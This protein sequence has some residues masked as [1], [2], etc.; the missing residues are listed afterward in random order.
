LAA[1]GSRFFLAVLQSL[2]DKISPVLTAD[3]T[4]GEPVPFHHYNNDLIFQV[5]VMTRAVTHSRA[6]TNNFRKKQASPTTKDRDG[7]LQAGYV[8]TD[9][10]VALRKKVV[11]GG[12]RAI[13]QFG[14]AKIGK[15]DAVG[16]AFIGAPR[17][18]TQGD[19]ARYH[20]MP[21]DGVVEQSFNRAALS[22][23]AGTNRPPRR[24]TM[25]RLTYR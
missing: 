2:P 19:L 14:D 1:L 24:L 11:V 10:E 13:M 9:S 20:W 3:S 25:S 12:V 16:S 8:G 7:C 5:K 21:G 6:A 22:A 15:Q 18:R 23:L 17:C 4:L